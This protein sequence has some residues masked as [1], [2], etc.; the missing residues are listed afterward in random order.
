MAAHRRL[1]APASALLLAASLS[2]CGG[3][4]PR[5]S[6]AAL[7]RA[8]RSTLDRTPALH[9]SLSSA[10][11]SGSGVDLVGG[12]GELARPDSLEGTFDVSSSGVQVSVKV[13]A[14]GSRF[15]AVLPFRSSYSRVD[16][17]Q[18]GLTDPGE[19]L[20]PTRG[21][22]EL[23]TGMAATAR[24][25]PAVRLDGE[26]LYVVTGSVPGSEVPVLPDAEPS[27]PVRLRV[28][29]DPASHQV[30]QVEMTGPFTSATTSRFT[31]RLTAYGTHA[32]ISPPG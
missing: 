8:A 25:Q 10:G 12:R 29:I 23:L 6:A 27:R 19:L 17:T 7:L 30:R 18:F 4:A 9:F 5:P 13:I 24:Y 20:S 14:V 3:S 1:L 15:W 31:V 21:L 16:P 11:V 28:D 22:A 2:A 32:A 26:L